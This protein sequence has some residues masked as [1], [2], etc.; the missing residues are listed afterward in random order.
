[1]MAVIGTLS[2]NFQVVFPL[3]A[4]CSLGG[5]ATLFTLLYSVVSVGLADRRAGRRPAH[6][7]LG[8][9]GGHGRPRPSA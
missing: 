2:Y 8:A 7:D 6:D 9:A 3:F 1:M 5:S 4:K